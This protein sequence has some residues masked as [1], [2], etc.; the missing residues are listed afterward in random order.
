MPTVATSHV[1]DKIVYDTRLIVVGCYNVVVDLLS[2][3]AVTVVVLPSV[4]RKRQ[5][6]AAGHQGRG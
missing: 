5:V 1:D 6:G 4:R 3:I 2:D